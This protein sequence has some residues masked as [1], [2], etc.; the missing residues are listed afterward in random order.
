[1]G[2]FET[3]IYKGENGID[4]GFLNPL[5]FFR[6]VE[7]NRGEDAGNA[8]LGLTAKYK[9]T[10]QVSLYSQLIIDEF[11][12]GNI[13]N[14]SDWRNKFAY[15]LGAKYFNAFKVENLFLQGEFNYARPYTFAHR[16][17]ILNYGNYAQPLAHLWGANFWEAIGIA[18][19]KKGR[20]SGSAKI[21]LG[22]KGFDFDQTTSYGGDIY[23]SYDI[24]LGDTGN[25]LTQGNSA[26]IF[27]GD[28]QANYLL[29]PSNNL[30]LFAGFTFRNFSP[31]TSSATFQKETTTWFTVGLR[32][33]LFNWYLD[34]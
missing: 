22:K 31:E 34:F 4:A 16:N 13:D 9:L 26:T 11:S 5:I 29:N 10:D 25:E 32:A 2:L 27:V 23:Q 21:V 28:V 1:M 3:A 8:I 7:F 33:D 15:Q 20:W 30:N 19:Y 12:V 17:P 18:R 14:L 24:R 6:S